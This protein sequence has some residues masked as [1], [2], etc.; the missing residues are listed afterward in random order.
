MCHL[1]VAI[2]QFECAAT[3]ARDHPR[4]RLRVTHQHWR[5]LRQ[6]N[7]PGPV[8]FA[9]LVHM[10]VAQH[11]RYNILYIIMHAPGA[12]AHEYNDSSAEGTTLRSRRTAL[13]ALSTTRARASASSRTRRG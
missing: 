9:E 3:A 1:E 5:L 13:L 6:R 12:M 4:A 2:A 11:M 8:C 10:Q 7:T